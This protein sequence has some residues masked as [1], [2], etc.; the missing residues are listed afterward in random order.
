M[1]GVSSAQARHAV[2]S[3]LSPALS[4]LAGAYA[5]GTGPRQLLLSGPEGTG[6]KTLAVLLAQALLCREENSPC[7][8]C[9]ACGS[10]E[11]GAHPNLV[12]L[13]A[14]AGKKTIRVE[15]ARALLRTLSAF[16]FSPGARPV[17]ILGADTLTPAAQNALLKAVEEPDA[18]T[19]FILTC[20]REKAVLPTI[21]SR[22]RTV[23]MPPWPDALIIEVLVQAGVPKDE[24]KSLADLSGASPGTALSIR[25]DKAFWDMKRLA[26]A[27]VLG[28]RGLSGLPESSRRMRDAKDAADDLLDYLEGAALRLIRE[29]GPQSPD[30]ARAGRLLEAVFAA[31]EQRAVNVSWQGVADTL[32]LSLLEESVSC[33]PSLA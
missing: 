31:R 3:R 20:T 7:G 13:R 29:G 32:L 33:P 26:D 14:D 17:L 28:L 19:W 16:P 30:A 8:S 9:Q 12:I 24:A 25:G 5:A 15:Q 10:T 27:A 2:F 22:C 11:S 6:K 23:R 4:A 18:A 1:P 21:R